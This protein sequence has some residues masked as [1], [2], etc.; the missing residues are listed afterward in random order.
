MLKSDEV[1]FVIVPVFSMTHLKREVEK[2][3]QFS[4][5]IR[6]LVF[7]NCG[8][9]LD[10]TEQWFYQSACCSAYLIDYHRPFHHNNLIDPARKIFVFDDGCKSFVECPTEDDVRIFQELQAQSESDDED[11]DEENSSE[12]LSEKLSEGPKEAGENEEIK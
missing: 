7:L 3:E 2:L 8:G 6:S 4:A 11:E 10:L 12:E 9:M 1:Q 5:V